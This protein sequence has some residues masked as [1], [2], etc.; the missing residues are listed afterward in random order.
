MGVRRRRW[1]GWVPFLLACS[2]VSGPV[3]PAGAAPLPDPS[4]GVGGMVVE[5]SVAR[6]TDVVS[7]ADGGV[8]ATA[9]SPGGD[10]AAVLRYDRL[11]RLVPTFGT[12]G[13]VVIARPGYV[14]TLGHI[15]HGPGGTLVVFGSYRSAVTSGPV[16]A[17][18][19]A[20][21][22]RLDPNFAT[23]GVFV[24]HFGPGVVCSGG[25]VFPDGRALVTCTMLVPAQP[26]LIA[27]VLDARGR[28]AAPFGGP[29][30]EVL[31]RLPAGAEASGARVAA[32][33][34]IVVGVNLG[35]G[36]FGAVRLLP[37]GA[38]DTTFS[39]DGLATRRPLGPLSGSG[40]VAVVLAPG[41]R[42]VVAA[43]SIATVA[44]TGS[45]DLAVVRF[46]RTGAADAAFAGGRGYA[47]IARMAVG[48]L[49]K[50]ADGSTLVV[51]Y[52]PPDPGAA[53]AP[54]RGAA[55]RAAQVSAAGVVD[56]RFGSSGIL[57]PFDGAATQSAA[58]AAAVGPGG[59]LT[60]AGG[61]SDEDP[62]LGGGNLTI[63]RGSVQ[64]FTTSAPARRAATIEAG[65]AGPYGLFHSCGASPAA[66]CS[67]RTTWYAMGNAWPLA[68]SSGSRVVV[69]VDRRGATGRWTRS[70]TI[71]TFVTDDGNFRATGAPS[72]V[73]LYR[74]RA[75]VPASASTL[76][77]YGPWR[78]FR[79]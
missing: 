3:A 36:T 24:R 25:A 68:S 11:G 58:F 41:G 23:A 10:T 31:V 50:L 39:G 64:R 70:R 27:T 17:R 34:R 42:V 72:S 75:A 35:H 73:G 16:V 12:A 26:W 38:R 19:D 47:R 69:Q 6:F 8:A 28:M 30:G 57:R 14:I 46:T 78:Y 5:T 32:D 59:A 67:I 48:H 49:V 40:S 53:D 51:G 1:W 65:L 20:E 13:A 76:L 71:G 21:T 52:S 37:S 63:T 33:G 18:L 61:L 62:L 22:G 54:P 66:P 79:R 77:T 74:V 56:T 43:T 29:D 55:G 44:G 2:V 4:F 45:E 9:L 15:E 60:F 7:T